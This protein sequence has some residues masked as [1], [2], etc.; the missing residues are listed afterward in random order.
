M[1]YTGTASVDRMFC[2][3]DADE[4]AWD[5][6]PPLP[7]P[8]FGLLAADTGMVYMYTGMSMGPLDLQVEV[9]DD[10]PDLVD[11]G[12]EDI[13]EVPLQT[14]SDIATVLTGAEEPIEGFPDTVLAAGAGTYRVRA[15]AAGRDLAW[16]LVV[17]EVIERYK[18]QIWPAPYAPPRI[19]QHRSAH[20]VMGY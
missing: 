17:D 9:L 11:S 10:V 20:A 12:W 1:L 8:G 7:E 14:Y 13:E 15:Y 18:L 2:V 4:R 3:K 6:L 19:V 16:D 5:E